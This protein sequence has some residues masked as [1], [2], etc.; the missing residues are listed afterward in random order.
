MKKTIFACDHRI[1]R[2]TL[3]EGPFIRIIGGAEKV[4]VHLK[5]KDGRWCY[6]THWRRKEYHRMNMP[7]RWSI[8]DNMQ[9]EADKKLIKKMIDIYVEYAVDKTFFGEA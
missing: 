3:V 9:Y 6:L 7:I 8:V 1:Y 5:F 2:W 4:V